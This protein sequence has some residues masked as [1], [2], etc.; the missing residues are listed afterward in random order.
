MHY[1]QVG[2]YE[3]YMYENMYMIAHEQAFDKYELDVMI[4]DVIDEY[5][6]KYATQKEVY[7]K[8]KIKPCN[9][10]IEQMFEEVILTGLSY[11]YGFKIC[12]PSTT[13]SLYN[14]HLFRKSPRG[15]EDFLAQRYKD[16][17]IPLT[18]ECSICNKKCKILN[19]RK[20]LE[21]DNH[22]SNRRCMEKDIN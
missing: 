14:Y 16:Y 9:I 17:D 7:T 5:V 6:E 1:Y 21:E 8:C 22:E 13:I 11:K 15:R 2:N 19:K 12:R 4:Q 10:D 20:I 3:P 18:Y